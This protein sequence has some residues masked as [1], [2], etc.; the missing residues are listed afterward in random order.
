MINTNEPIWRR[1]YPRTYTTWVSLRARCNNQNHHK[2][3][4]YGGVGIKVCPEWD[5]FE[6][7]LADMGTRP[8]GCTIDRIDSTGDYTKSNCRW[9]NIHIQNRNRSSVKLS[10]ED[11]PFIRLFAQHG[12]PNTKIANMFG[13]DNS[14]I[15]KI[16]KGKI[17]AD[18]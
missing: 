9:S 6:V 14:S 18:C 10:E 5:D 17:W 8:E 2:Y 7:F 11:I 15:G 12:Y 1:I 3:P 4:I 16:L 13:V